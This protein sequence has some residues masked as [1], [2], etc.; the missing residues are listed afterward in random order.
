MK[1]FFPLL[2]K[3]INVHKK[4]FL[5]IPYMVIMIFFANKMNFIPLIVLNQII[6]DL[7]FFISFII[8]FLVKIEENQSLGLNA[9]LTAEYKRHNVIISRYNF[10]L[11]F[12]ATAFIV[13]EIT[14]FICF[15]TDKTDGNTLNF[16]PLYL[17]SCFLFIGAL[18]SILLF[19]SFSLNIFQFA[20]SAA[21]ISTII[22]QVFN[23]FVSKRLLHH[24]FFYFLVEIFVASGI[25]YV[26][27][28][29]TSLVFSKKDL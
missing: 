6:L 9:L 25:I 17:S 28:F 23:I 29:V 24:S 10:T 1:K 15:I 20:I 5:L 22:S 2:L 26:L 27:L 11:L 19:L 3:E 21:V 8:L 12:V 13:N 14:V 7:N 16:S 4:N 18:S